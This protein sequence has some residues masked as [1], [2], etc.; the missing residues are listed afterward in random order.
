[1][2]YVAMNSEVVRPPAINMSSQSPSVTRHSRLYIAF[3]SRAGETEEHALQLF[4]LFSMET[5]R[6]S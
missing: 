4:L 1:M 5:S 3:G 2:V 6:G